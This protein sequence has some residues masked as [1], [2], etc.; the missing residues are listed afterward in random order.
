MNEQS[1]AHEWRDF[2]RVFVA[3]FFGAAAIAT[4]LFVLVDPYDS[5]RLGLLGIE[6]VHERN[7]RFANVSRGRDGQFDSAIFGNSTGQLINPASLSERT[8]KRFV[9]L[10]APGTDPIGQL[11]I[12]RFFLRHHENVAALVIF[13]DDPWCA[14]DLVNPALNDFPFWLYNENTLEYL[15][16]LY[17]WRS[18]ERSV[19][20]IGIGLGLK[21]RM[22]PD[23]FWSY[24]DV[25]PP[26][27]YRPDTDQQ[28]EQPRSIGFVRTDFP[29]RD[30]LASIIKTVSEDVSLVIVSPPKF[31]TALP[32]V[33]SQAAAER[34]ACNAAFR[35]LLTSR[36]RSALLD[37]GISNELTRDPENFADF[38]HYRSHIAEDIEQ[39]LA[40]I[41]RGGSPNDRSK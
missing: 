1:E 8:G 20:R 30:S 41:I 4:L 16:H 10:V 23:G 18:I 17:N 36:S 25:W 2:L 31:H 39:S 3:T 35:L 15:A 19:Q 11:A 22:H 29:A 32:Q 6:G 12:L 24:E 13:I 21:D 27:K 7:A 26:G 9:Q 14:H 40:K 37:L 34:E 38:I 28:P 33:G 5:G